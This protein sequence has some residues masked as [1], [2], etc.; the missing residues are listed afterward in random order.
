MV[1][2]PNNLAQRFGVKRSFNNQQ[3]ATTSSS[4]MAV[5]QN[6]VYNNESIKRQK[7]QKYW[8]KIHVHHGFLSGWS[9]VMIHWSC[10]MIHWRGWS[11]V[12]QVSVMSRWIVI[13]KWMIWLMVKIASFFFVI[14]N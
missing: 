1:Q 7:C 6:V 5:G 2:E 12:R 3:G 11:V 10:I 9:G 13:V 8:S 4:D 14:C